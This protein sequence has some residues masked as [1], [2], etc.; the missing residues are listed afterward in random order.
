ML[1]INNTSHIIG[2]SV[3]HPDG[4]KGNYRLNWPPGMNEVKA[5]DWERLEGDD[6]VQ[7]HVDRGEL[8]LLS[9]DT[10]VNISTMTVRKAIKTIRS[11]FDSER[12]MSWVGDEDRPGVLKAIEDQIEKIEASTAKD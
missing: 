11:V 7:G 1:I 12:L 6:F 3:T 9:D 8:E 2:P 5:E 4:A 10:S